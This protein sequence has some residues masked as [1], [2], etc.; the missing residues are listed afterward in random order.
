MIALFYLA[1]LFQGKKCYHFWNSLCYNDCILRQTD[2]YQENKMQ[3]LNETVNRLNAMRHQ[4]I[5]D[6]DHQG[7]KSPMYKDAKKI[8][9]ILFAV[10]TGRSASSRLAT[11][12]KLLTKW[13]F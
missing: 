10:Q 9:Q 5:A 4:I 6:T 12:A 7:E 8:E 13:G 1:E 2:N 3:S 11:A